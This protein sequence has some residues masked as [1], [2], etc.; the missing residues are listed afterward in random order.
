MN[1]DEICKA[2]ELFDEG[3]VSELYEFIRPFLK[4]ND[5]YALYF[6]SCFSLVEWN[7]S[8]EDF[9]RRNLDLLTKAAAADVAPAMYLLSSSYFTGDT[10]KMDV[11][12]GKSYLD[13]ALELGYEPA[14]LAVGIN[15]YYGS[16]G[17]PK[18]I[19]KAL[20]LVL[21]AEKNK[22]DGAASTLDHIQKN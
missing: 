12:V 5:P 3:L 9:D 11:Q 17:Y 10:V 2:N 18:D 20:E 15:Y 19:E 13:R 22:V 7:E 1:Q 8:G 14:K 6:S 16:N 21:D 4:I